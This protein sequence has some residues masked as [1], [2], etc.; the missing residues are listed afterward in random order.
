MKKFFASAL[1]LV[2]LASCESTRTHEPIPTAKR[3]FNTK[4]VVRPIGEPIQVVYAM[5]IDTA[6]KVGDT[7]RVEY[8][9]DEIRNA[10]VVR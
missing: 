9:H 4:R 7:I 2:S 10:V 3:A 8:T 5:Y 6:Y 1:I